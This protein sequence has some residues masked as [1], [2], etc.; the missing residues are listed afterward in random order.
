MYLY[1]A[2]V[3]YEFAIPFIKVKV[4]PLS[5][6][7]LEEILMLYKCVINNNKQTTEY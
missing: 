4:G 7:T 2:C 3:Q 1:D 5:T 6:E